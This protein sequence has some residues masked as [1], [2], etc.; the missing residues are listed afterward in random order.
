M[1]YVD[2]NNKRVVLQI[3]LDKQIKDNF[4]A[5][6]KQKAINSSELIRQFIE[7]WIQE[8]K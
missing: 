4:Q 2:E 7:K 6:C 1:A 5:T 8:N 3:R